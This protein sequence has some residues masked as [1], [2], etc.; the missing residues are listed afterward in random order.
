[1]LILAIDTALGAVAACAYNGQEGRIVA[2]ERIFL[3]RGH[4]EALVPLLA[5]LEAQIPN[6]LAAVERVAVTTGPGSFT[7]IRVGIAAARAAG[8]ACGVDVVGVSTLS[9]FAA[10]LLGC[11]GLSVGCA[12]DARH[13][14]V[15]F[16]SFDHRGAV[17][18]EAA[19]LPVRQ[20]AAL[21]GAGQTI[22]TGPGAT[23]VA[24]EAWSQ[25][26]KAEVGGEFVSPAI[27]YVAR[28]GILAD[29]A[30]SPPQPF[31]LK[32]ADVTVKTPVL[33]QV[34]P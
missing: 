5:R 17:V 9:A 29:S 21:L 28:L 25:G 12:I 27:E 3:D 20:A 18:H 16:E 33:M 10:P 11:E 19:V 32:A 13:G 15:Y 22:L 6:G 34:V 31:Y 24:I 2:S 26:R 23:L 1:M 14:N 7:G 8:L 4:A 30:E